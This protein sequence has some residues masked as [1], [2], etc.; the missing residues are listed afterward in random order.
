MGSGAPANSKIF[1][2]SEGFILF[3][4]RNIRVFAISGFFQKRLS[5]SSSSKSFFTGKK[6]KNDFVGQEGRTRFLLC[7]FNFFLEKYS[8]VMRYV[9][10]SPDFPVSNPL[11]AGE[12]PSDIEDDFS[13]DDENFFNLASTSFFVSESIYFH[14]QSNSLIQE[15]LYPPFTPPESLPVRQAGVTPSRI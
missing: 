8:S 12:V 6:S 14:Q 10:E 11:S 5:K 9:P 13:E 2:F 3:R 1:G 15:S 7:L 4:N